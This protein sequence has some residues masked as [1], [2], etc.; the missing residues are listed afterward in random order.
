MAYP[1]TL[2][3]AIRHFS[4][5]QICIDAVAEMRW[6]DGKPAVRVVR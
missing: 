3:D 6:P 2:Q 4:D 5:E 1:T